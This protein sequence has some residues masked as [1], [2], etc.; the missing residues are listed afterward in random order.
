[1]YVCIT[2]YS[3]ALPGQLA[4]R[5]PRIKKGSMIYTDDTDGTNHIDC[6]DDMDCIRS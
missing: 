3:E 4:L 5:A 6:M 1:M 2:F